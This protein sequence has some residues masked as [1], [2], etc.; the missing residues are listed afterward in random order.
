MWCLGGC[1]RC[2]GDLVPEYDEWRCL[3]CGHRYYPHPIIPKT[4]R[5][6]ITYHAWGVNHSKRDTDIV[7]A[8]KRGLK[9]EE[10]AKMFGLKSARHI[11]MIRSLADAR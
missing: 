2:Q 6:R 3:Q 4:G 1:E 10:V 11:R 9:T 8:L 5:D 7:K